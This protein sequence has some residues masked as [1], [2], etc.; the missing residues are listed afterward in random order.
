MVKT[1]ILITATPIVVFPTSAQNITTKWWI[2]NTK[3]IMPLLE[4]LIK[5]IML[6]KYIRKNVNKLCYI[7]NI[8]FIKILV[9]FIYF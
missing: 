1:R 5:L 8:F 4:F 2:S 7:V 6:N 3:Y 9:H